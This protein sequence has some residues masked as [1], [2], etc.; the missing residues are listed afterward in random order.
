MSSLRG[1]V[2][3]IVTLRRYH[4]PL[5]KPFDLLGPPLV[6]FPRETGT[7]GTGYKEDFSD[8]GEME[9]G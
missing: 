7:A 9:E 1:I 8:I 4:T 2:S 5:T 3:E 6:F